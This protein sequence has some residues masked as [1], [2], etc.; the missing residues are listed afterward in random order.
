M[1]HNLEMKVVEQSG[2]LKSWTDVYVTVIE[3]LLQEISFCS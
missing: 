3:L 2:K 1:L